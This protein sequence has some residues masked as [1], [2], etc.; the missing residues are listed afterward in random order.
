VDEFVIMKP[1]ELEMSYKNYLGLIIQSCA[2]IFICH[3][4]YFK[5]PLFYF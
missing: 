1:C 5:Y 2:Y 3:F 4:S